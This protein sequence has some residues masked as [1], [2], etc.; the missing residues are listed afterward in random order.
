MINLASLNKMRG[1]YDPIKCKD[2]IKH[3]ISD[4]AIEKTLDVITKK[5][6]VTREE[7]VKIMKDRYG[8]SFGTVDNAVR[9]LKTKR[10]VAS[11]FEIKNGSNCKVISLVK[12]LPLSQSSIDKVVSVLRDQKAMTVKNIA[13]YSSVAKST[14]I[15]V[16]NHLKDINSVSVEMISMNQSRFWEVTFLQYTIPIE[17]T[18]RKNSKAERDKVKSIAVDEYLKGGVTLQDIADKYSINIA[19]VHRLVSEKRGSNKRITGV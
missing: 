5:V 4:S 15:R 18:E 19:M 16:I 11:N 7:L 9:Y 8:I 1:D 10:I 3:Y 17:A 2:G 6:E 14:I 12:E 13:K